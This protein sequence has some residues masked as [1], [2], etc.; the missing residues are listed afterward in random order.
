MLT[1]RSGQ[2]A[3]HLVAAMRTGFAHRGYRTNAAHGG[4]PGYCIGRPIDVVGRRFAPEPRPVAPRDITGD[5]FSE[6]I[7]IT[8]P[9]QTR[10]APPSTVSTCPV[11]NSC[12]MR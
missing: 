12:S 3:T 7:P 11:P 2:M 4:A 1:R 5:V 10:V 6:Y 9:F 8:A